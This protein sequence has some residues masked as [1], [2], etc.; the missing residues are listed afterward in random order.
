M[1]KTSKA[2]A[3]ATTMP[4]SDAAPAP[5]ASSETQVSRRT[6]EHGSDKPNAEVALF[7]ACAPLDR[8][9]LFTL[10]DGVRAL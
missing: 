8:D 2:Q 1:K 6:G 4:D 5:L 9:L 7:A 10:I 3:T